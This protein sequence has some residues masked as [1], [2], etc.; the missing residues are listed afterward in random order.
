MFRHVELIFGGL[1]EQIY[2]I[3]DNDIF[4]YFFFYLKCIFSYFRLIMNTVKRK[5]LTHKVPV[6]PLYRN[7]S[8]DLLCK[9][10][11]WFL[12]EGITGTEWVK[13]LLA[14]YIRMTI[15]LIYSRILIDITS[16]C[17][18]KL[19]PNFLVQNIKY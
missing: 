17:F 4:F 13:Q 12:Y 14:F 1:Y 19:I 8:I 3:I 11:D 16:A 18:V 5:C 2:L 9:S 15:L 7:R 6:L 10:I